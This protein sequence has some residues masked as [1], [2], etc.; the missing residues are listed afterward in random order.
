MTPPGDYGPSAG[1][2][3]GVQACGPLGAPS[4]AA[5][6][7]AVN[8]EARQEKVR[9]LVAPALWRFPGAE[10][11]EWSAGK[12]ICFFPAKRFSLCHY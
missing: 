8:Y 9:L 7:L 11:D 5:G 4:G 1:T 10:G 6:P 2:V 12:I 3:G